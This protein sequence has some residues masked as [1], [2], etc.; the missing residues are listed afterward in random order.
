MHRFAALSVAVP[1]VLALGACGGESDGA[2]GA[3][4]EQ[5]AA[6]PLEIKHF[7]SALSVED[8]EAETAFYIDVLNFE[9]VKD[10]PLGE[11][12]HFRWLRNGTQGIELVQ[13]AG[14]QPGPKR[15]APPAHFLVRGP[16]QLMME[17]ADLEATKAR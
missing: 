8:I 14:S 16:G 11:E 6:G 7:M 1:L 9:V 10:V 3:P 17:V 5:A 15:E 12:M 2:A 13:M 4:A